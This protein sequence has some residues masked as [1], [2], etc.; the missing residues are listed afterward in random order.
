MCSIL[1]HHSSPFLHSNINSEKGRGG[2]GWVRVEIPR[3]RLTMCHYVCHK[4]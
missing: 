4:T 2:G 3:D 1:L